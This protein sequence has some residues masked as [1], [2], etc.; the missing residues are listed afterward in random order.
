[1]NTNAETRDVGRS[2]DVSFKIFFFTKITLN[3][4]IV[5]IPIEIM[6]QQNVIIGKNAN[7]TLCD[8]SYRV[9][10]TLFASRMS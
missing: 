9:S 7:G 5:K 1:M 10:K 2:R 3:S 8:E 6:T 4:G